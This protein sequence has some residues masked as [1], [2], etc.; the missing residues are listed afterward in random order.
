MLEMVDNKERHVPE[1]EPKRNKFKLKSAEERRLR[2][3][4]K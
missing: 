3:F 4:A 1:Y 2:R